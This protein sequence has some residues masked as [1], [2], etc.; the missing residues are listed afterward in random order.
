MVDVYTCTDNIFRPGGFEITDRAISYCNFPPNAKLADIGCGYGATVKY[1]QQNYSFNIWGVEKDREILKTVN[2]RNV[3]WG[4]AA[5]LPFGKAEMDGL[6]FECSFSKMKY[7]ETVLGECFRVIKPKGYLI[8][9]DLFARGKGEVLSGLLGR[10]ETKE[11]LLYRVTQQGF[12]IELFEDYSS[13]LQS[14]WGQ[15][16]LQYGMDGLCQNLSTTRENLRDIKCGYCLIIA[17]REDNL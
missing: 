2:N 1:I 13:T 14:M 6:F 7:P 12:N 3:L 4:D 5:Q 15:L 10:V 11:E 17:R 8:I 9:S 16:I